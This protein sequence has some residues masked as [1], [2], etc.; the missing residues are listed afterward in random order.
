MVASVGL[1]C[2]ALLCWVGGLV[3]GVCLFGLAGFWSSVRF[4][5]GVSV[6]FASWCLLVRACVVCV[7]IWC[8]LWVVGI[9]VLVFCCLLGF[10]A[11]LFA[12]GGGVWFACH[13]LV[14]WI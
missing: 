12:F 8:S 1:V 14:V 11:S 3:S 10:L 9:W 5:F 4:R 7:W 2:L 13:D 6:F